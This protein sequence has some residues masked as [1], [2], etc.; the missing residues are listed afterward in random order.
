MIA[1]L[2]ISIVPPI[3]KR[4]RYRGRAIPSVGARCETGRREWTIAEHFV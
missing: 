3:L 1:G 2:H 4:G